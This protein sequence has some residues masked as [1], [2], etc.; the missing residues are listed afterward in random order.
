MHDSGTTDG[1]ERNSAGATDAVGRRRFVALGAG[2]S[3]TLLAGCSGATDSDGTTADGDGTG[4]GSTTE[5]GSDGSTT[6]G[7]FRL[8]V[9]DQPADIGDFEELNVTLDHARVFR[10]EGDDEGDDEETEDESET[11][12]GAESGTETA[13][14]TETTTETATAEATTTEATTEAESTD[15]DAA[16]ETED[17][18]ED[19]DEEED[20]SEEDENDDGENGF[21]E[22]DLDGRTVDLTEVVGDKAVSVFDGELPAGR[23]TKV[24]LH[25]RDAEGIVD[26]ETVGVKVPS[27]KL[28]I[29][30]PFEVVAGESLSFVFDINVVKKG[31]TG[32]YNLLPVISESGVA[33]EDVDVEEVG[34]EGEDDE[35][36]DGTEEETE[37]GETDEEP[38]A[39][40]ETDGGSPED[41]GGN[42][43]GD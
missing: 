42:S 23:Y 32:E 1:E 41:G 38:T 35:D 31:N 18:D 26:G 2:A 22:I 3:A 16:D 20:E 25:V 30:K 6:V 29:V 27:E 24:E 4:D 43:G 8:L 19:A 11:E 33:G 12:D 7:S 36:G 13:E 34:D 15:E 40:A 28:Q 21:S 39:T 37:T 5:S 17:D 9:S 14:S 10:G